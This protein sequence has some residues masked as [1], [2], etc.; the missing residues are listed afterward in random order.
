MCDAD[1]VVDLESGGR[2]EGCCSADSSSC[3][4]GAICQDGKWQSTEQSF[5]WVL[6]FYC[7]YEDLSE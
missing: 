5:G 4:E 6:V 2:D 1:D 3:V 7:L